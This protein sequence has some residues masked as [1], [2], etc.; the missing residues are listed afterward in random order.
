[1]FYWDDNKGAKDKPSDV[2]ND[3]EQFEVKTVA[4]DDAQATSGAVSSV[5]ESAVEKLSDN[6]NS[7]VTAA[8]IQN[9]GVTDVTEIGAND[10]SVC[11]ADESDDELTPDVE[12]IGEAFSTYIIVRFKDSLYIIDKHAAHERILFNELKNNQ[13]NDPQMLLAPLQVVL[14]RDEYTVIT[15]NSDLLLKAGFEI[16]D[17]G[18]STVLV[19]SVPSALSGENVEGLVSEIAASIAD[20][21]A[22]EVER[23]ERIYETISCRSAVKAGNISS[24]LE[25]KALA[26]K[27]LSS[28]EIMY[29]PHGR[30]VAME[31][32]KREIEKQFGRIQ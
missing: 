3:I 31:L 8:E 1:M 5:V 14:R 11:T 22:V 21:N 29:C 28:K 20:K 9:G 4:T 12:Y 16:E 24:P 13:Q 27:V 26:E 30:P 18:D 19:R 7:E 17:Y 25:L 2:D 10:K 32:K 15:E 6:L 23:L